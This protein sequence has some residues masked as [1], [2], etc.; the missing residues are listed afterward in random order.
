MFSLLIIIP[1]CALTHINSIELTLNYQ[2]E[3]LTLPIKVG[4]PPQDFDLLFDTTTFHLWLPNSTLSKTF[5]NTFSI[6]ESSSF[7][8][9]QDNKDVL[10]IVG[11]KGTDVLDFVDFY[12][13]SI[14]ADK[15]FHLILIDTTQGQEVVLHL[16]DGTIGFARKYL[17]KMKQVK[18]SNYVEANPKFSIVQ[19]LYNSNIIDSKAFDLRFISNNQAKLTLGYYPGDSKETIN[20]CTV[21]D[22]EVTESLIPLW[23]CKSDYISFSEEKQKVFPNETIVILD[24]S[25]DYI[26]LASKTATEIF[27]VLDNALGLNCIRN[28]VTGLGISYFCPGG[29]NTNKVPNFYIH[30]AEGFDLKITGKDLFKEY[31]IDDKGKNLY[32]YR[33]NIISNGKTNIMY[34]GMNFIKHY[35]IVFDKEE[36]KI[37]FGDYIGEEI[38]DYS[39]KPSTNIPN[40]TSIFKWFCIVIVLLFIAVIGF[41]L[42]RRSQLKK[43]YRK[44]IVHKSHSDSDNL[45]EPIGKPMVSV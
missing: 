27:N 18:Q 40:E 23:L 29:I 1:L 38:F 45:I 28:V 43:R 8:K 35:H 21:N 24:S 36:Y 32:G 14:K 26:Q 9:D 10:Q 44:G 22:T 4:T 19:Y 42:Y 6:I 34:L 33:A 12:D 7:E 30:I 15:K 13:E 25:I 37:G 11:Q 3:L 39:K 2:N 31:M 16:F 17:G 41:W 5:P 20:Y